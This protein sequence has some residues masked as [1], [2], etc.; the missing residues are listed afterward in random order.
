MKNIKQCKMVWSHRSRLI[1][2]YRG[3]IRISY[4][5]SWRQSKHHG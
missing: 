4:C 2:A 3:G 1:C 5:K